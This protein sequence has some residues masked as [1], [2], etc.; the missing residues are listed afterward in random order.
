MN[1]VDT[2]FMAF[3]AFL[4]LLLALLTERLAYDSYRKRDVLWHP[5]LLIIGLIGASLYFWGISLY[6][7]WILV[8]A[9]LL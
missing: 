3:A 4:G 7:I 9:Y 8:Q 5:V 6:S 1:P 2:V